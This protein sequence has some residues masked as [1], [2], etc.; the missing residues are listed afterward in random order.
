MSFKYNTDIWTT[1]DIP[2]SQD[3]Y[4]FWVYKDDMFQPVIARLY[5]TCAGDTVFCRGPVDITESLH[6]GFIR[7]KD[8]ILVPKVD[9]LT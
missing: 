4:R 1:K 9:D 2:L 6:E 7:S 5:R 8:P 3:G